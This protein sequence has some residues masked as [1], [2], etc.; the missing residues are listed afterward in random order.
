M[1]CVGGGSRPP[2]SLSVSRRSPQEN[3]PSRLCEAVGV[4]IASAPLHY[5]GAE[6]L[7]EVQ[8]LASH[9]VLWGWFESADGGRI[10]V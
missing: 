6:F 8:P 7:E 10:K 9:L 1:S 3:S 2:F 4:L 5:Q